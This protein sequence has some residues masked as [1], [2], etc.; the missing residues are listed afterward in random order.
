MISY[1]KSELYRILHNKG[2]YL[3]L[4]ICSA[5]LI[6]ANVILALVGHSDKTFPYANTGFSLSLFY[7]SLSMIFILC[8]SVTSIV[9]GNEHNYHTM[10]NTVSYGISR[11]SIYFGKLIVTFLYALSAFLIIG[12]LF[13]LSSYA[14]L[15]NSHSQD[16][17]RLFKA[18]FVALP[19]LLFAVAASNCF[20]FL[21][22]STGGAIAA[23]VGVLVAFPEISNY[24]AMKFKFFQHLAKILP[25]NLI[26]KIGFDFQTDSSNLILPW[27]GMSGYYNYWLFGMLQLILF[28]IIGYTLFRKKEIK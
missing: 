25:W 18:S 19:L 17:V 15:E 20:F 26:N 1:I 10:K 8:I 22:E 2:S 13:I 14:L 6:S 7:T 27:E 5:L 24:L 21:L 28:V 12:G 4:L 11:G 9:F 3:F 16:L 23:I